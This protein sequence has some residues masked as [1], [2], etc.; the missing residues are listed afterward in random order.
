MSDRTRAV[1]SG[2]YPASS[3]IGFVTIAS[4]GNETDWGANL[5]RTS[6]IGM[7]IS[8]S[9]RGVQAGS[10]STPDHT[11]MDYITIQSAGTV[12]DFGDLTRGTSHGASVMSPTR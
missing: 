11:T 6:Y 12:A 4:T 10:Y 5:T 9:T 1:F 8:N 2:A 7:A 3:E